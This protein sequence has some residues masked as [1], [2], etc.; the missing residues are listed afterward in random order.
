MAIINGQKDQG[1]QP[2]GFNET[3][4]TNEDRTGRTE[5]RSDASLPGEAAEQKGEA[6][7]QKEKSSEG[8]PGRSAADSTGGQR[9]AGNAQ[10]A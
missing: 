9:P 4:R 8:E 10:D 5:E 6:A 2:I 7:E 1:R 3:G